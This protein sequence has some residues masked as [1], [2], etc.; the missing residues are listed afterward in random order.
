MPARDRFSELPA[1]LRLQIYGHALL[2]FTLPEIGK[3]QAPEHPLLQV[4]KLFRHKCMPVYSARLLDILDQK[5]T[6]LN[7]AEQ[8]SSV[9]KNGTNQGM[10]GNGEHKVELILVAAEYE[11]ALELVYQKQRWIYLQIYGL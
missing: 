11:D 5:K 1:E 8:A 7:R 6:A 2:N 9:S 3:Y 10:S 4:C